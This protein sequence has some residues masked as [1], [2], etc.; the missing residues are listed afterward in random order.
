MLDYDRWATSRWLVALPNLQNLGRAHEILE[1]MLSAQQIWLGRIGVEMSHGQANV[2]LAA[3]FDGLHGLWRRVAE[4]AAL[5][6]VI[7]YKT[8]TGDEFQNSIG[9]IAYHVVNHGT[10]HRGQLRGLAESEGFSG[11]PDTDLILFLRE[12]A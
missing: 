8:S 2:P 5:E 3:V 10:Y 9:E 6:E 12:S 11:F 1:H 4:E 7:T